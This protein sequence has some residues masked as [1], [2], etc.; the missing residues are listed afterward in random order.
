MIIVIVGGNRTDIVE[1]K[2][3]PLLIHPLYHFTPLT[4]V[5]ITNQIVIVVK[6]FV[7]VVVV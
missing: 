4:L 1:H 6:S 3:I 5:I 7:I 2:L